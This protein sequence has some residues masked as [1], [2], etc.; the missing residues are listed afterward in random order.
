[1]H[2]SITLLEGGTLDVQE[3]D[4]NLILL[5]AIHNKVPLIAFSHFIRC[6]SGNEKET[7]CLGV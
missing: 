1:M 4:G 7:Q 3:E 2:I 6:A 5:S